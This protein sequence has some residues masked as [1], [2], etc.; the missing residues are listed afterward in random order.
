MNGYHVSAI[1]KELVKSASILSW[2]VH[3]VV[4]SGVV[5]DL[6]VT[7]VGHPLIVLDQDLV[8][9]GGILL[10]ETERNIIFNILCVEQEVIHDLSGCIGIFTWRHNHR[11]GCLHCIVFD[12]GGDTCRCCDQWDLVWFKRC[13]GRSWIEDHLDFMLLVGVPIRVVI[14]G[15]VDFCTDISHYIVFIARGGM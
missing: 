14:P 10:F 8:E 7:V 9:G 2:N 15:M 4:I 6:D 3:G 12:F 5:N 11:D 1:S 13:V